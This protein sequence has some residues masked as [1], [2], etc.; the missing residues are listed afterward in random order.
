VLAR[1]VSDEFGMPLDM[2]IHREEAAFGAALVASVGLGILPGREAA[3]KLIRYQDYGGN[4]DS[5]RS[6]TR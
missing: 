5:G 3:A 2:A 1:I 4:S 6:S